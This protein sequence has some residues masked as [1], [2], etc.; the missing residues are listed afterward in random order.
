M[1]NL[2]QG[3]IWGEKEKHSV[4]QPDLHLTGGTMAHLPPTMRMPMILSK[5]MRDQLQHVRYLL[6]LAIIINTHILIIFNTA[7]LFLIYL[8]RI[9]I[10]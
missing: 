5:N 4:V 7:Y 3:R 1:L 2:Y 9:V 8:I 6:I 10:K